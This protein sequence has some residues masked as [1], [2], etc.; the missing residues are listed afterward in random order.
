MDYILLTPVKNE[1]QFLND[2]AQAL[3]RQ[4]HLPRL[5]LIVDDASTDST[6]TI[7]A[8][9]CARHDWIISHTLPYEDGLL[10]EHFARVVRA[11]YLQLQ[12]EARQRDI[13]YDL[14]GKIDAD[15][16]FELDCFASLAA[17]FEKD[18]RLGIASP[19]LILAEGDEAE[20]LTTL[21]TDPSLSDHPTDGVR[22]YRK[23]CFEQID[24]MQIVRGTETVAEARALIHGWKLRRFTHIT[25]LHRRKS[26]RAVSLWKRWELVGAEQHYLGYHPLLVLGSCG[27]DLLVKKPKYL[28]LAHLIGYIKAVLRRQARIDDRE[29]IVYFGK[30]RLQ[31]IL[32]QIPSLFKQVIRYLFK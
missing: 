6:P 10:G 29:I 8:A 16:Y 4:V 22:L 32:P 3:T 11:G 19:N 7:I 24:G 13:S 27:Y 15:V 26:H 9:L 25:G 28:F 23:E 31:D 18:P 30:K 21:R 17:E 5:W 20:K 1:A 14:I 12:A 2:A